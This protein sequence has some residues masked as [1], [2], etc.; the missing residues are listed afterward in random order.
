M[1][2]RFVIRKLN[3]DKRGQKILVLTDMQLTRTFSPA[4]SMSDTEILIPSS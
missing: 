2:G 3:E 1:K 4:K